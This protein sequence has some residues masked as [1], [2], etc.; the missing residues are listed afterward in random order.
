MYKKVSGRAPINI[1]LI[2]YWGKKDPVEVIPYQP[3]ISLSLSIFETITTIQTHDED[4]F[5]FELNH[6]PHPKTQALVETFLKH[7]TDDHTLKNIYIHTYNTGPTA[8][9]LASSASGFAALAVTANHFFQ[10]N[11]SLEK[12]AEITRK[13]SGSAIRSLLPGCVM[14]D[15]DGGITSIP[16]PFEDVCMGI[17]I[18]NSREKEIG[19]TEAMKLSV[20]T[21]PLYA[22]WVE[23]SF[24]DRDQ[25]LSALQ[26]KDFHRMGEIAESNALHMHEVCLHSQPEV[27]YLTDASHQVIQMIQQLRHTHD[28]PLY[29]TMDAGPNVKILTRLA[30]QKDI[31]AYFKKMNIDIL[32]SSIDD[33][34][35]CIT[36][37]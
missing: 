20:E 9:G 12:L 14:W 33:K 30:F 27:K 29:A 5:K 17:I 21:S 15:V 4:T 7:F 36:H 37:E 24:I 18:I 16:F 28:I 23:K 22:H 1:A 19:S 35:A 11:Y 2:K 10:T 34:G 13:G 31:H 25:F 26:H 8:A 3:S 6:Q 32:W